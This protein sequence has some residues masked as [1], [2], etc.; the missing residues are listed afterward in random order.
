MVFNRAWDGIAI[1]LESP[2]VGG[3]EDSNLANGFSNGRPVAGFVLVPNHLAE[4]W[5][6]GCRVNRGLYSPSNKTNKFTVM[7]GLYR[8]QL[9]SWMGRE[10]DEGDLPSSL[11]W[12]KGDSPSSPAMRLDDREMDKGDAWWFCFLSTFQVSYP[13]TCLG[14][15]SGTESRLITHFRN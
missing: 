14:L 13:E 10:M 1:G 2:N 11:R 12:M 4:G 9:F 7:E 8:L 15:N 6:A 3:F 5:E